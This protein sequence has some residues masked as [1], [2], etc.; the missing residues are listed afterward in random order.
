MS[1]PRLGRLI[2]STVN[3]VLAPGGGEDQPASA[4]ALVAAA[5]RVAAEVLAPAAAEVDRAD[6]IPF[7][8]LRALAEAGLFGLAGPDGPGR[9]AGRRVYE[10]LAGACG[11]TFFVWVQHHAPVRLLVA[12]ANRALADRWLPGLL[13][14][15]V[16]GGV[17]FAHLRRPGPPAVV[18]ERVAGG[19]VLS[20]EAPWVTSWGMAGLFAVAAR[21]GDDVVFVAQPGA[22]GQPGA[23][24]SPPLPLA[25]MNAS[26]TVRL[27]LDRVPVGDDDV[28]EELPFAE[29]S[30]RDR[31]VTAQPNPAAFGVAATC[32]RLLEEAGSPVAPALADEWADCRARSFA[33][34]EDDVDRL[35]RLRAESLELAVRAAYALVVSTGG[36]SMSLDHPAQ[37]L[38]RE[39]SFYAIQAQTPVLR[40]ATL[41]RLI[42]CR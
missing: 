40:E 39:A 12:S 20:G 24:A 27:T 15:D 30:A 18:A 29:W 11:A 7:R 4:D 34:A 28:M 38:L 2:V 31:V 35:V 5:E 22:D 42:R 14:G 16:L 26:R 33:A 41:A 6:R 1:S 37:R 25:V 21:C 3:D 23:T 17:A 9:A 32:L 13:S 36:R 8:H 10:A 19:Y